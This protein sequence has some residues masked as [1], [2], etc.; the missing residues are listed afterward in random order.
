M[1]GGA[2]DPDAEIGPGRIRTFGK[3]SNA[4]PQCLRFLMQRYMYISERA[5]HDVTPALDRSQSKACAGGNPARTRT[6]CS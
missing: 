5:V 4:N 1:D 3:D 2:L 6:T